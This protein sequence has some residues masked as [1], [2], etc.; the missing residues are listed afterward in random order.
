MA[1][2]LDAFTP[3]VI[4][5]GAARGAD[6]LAGLWA[7]SR[8]VVVKPY[9]ADWEKHGRAAGPIRNRLM[10]DDFHP[11]LVVAFKD[12]FDYS[13]ESGGTEHMVKIA[14]AAGVE[15]RVVDRSGDG[16]SWSD[17]SPV[18]G[19]P[20]PAP[21][22]AAAASTGSTSAPKAPRPVT[23][24]LTSSSGT[25]KRREVTVGC[26]AENQSFEATTAWYSRTTCPD[27]LKRLEHA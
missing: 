15:C 7:S 1:D 14:R 19:G 24:I 2:E 17:P 12:G 18:K 10:L 26:G 9:P 3:A 5:H 21:V 8:H 23:H 22:V 6:R 27:C 25:G 20:A 16:P 13:L 4:C 11:D